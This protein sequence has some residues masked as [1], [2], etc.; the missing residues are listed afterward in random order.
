MNVVRMRSRLPLF[1]A[2]VVMA[3]WIAPPQPLQAATPSFDCAK[4]GTRVE[5]AICASDELARLDVELAN[6]YREALHA[7]TTSSAAQLAWL[8]QRNTCSGDELAQCL[9]GAMKTRIAGLQASQTVAIN[10]DA[11]YAA[12]RTVREHIEKAPLPAS[13]YYFIR[14][15]KNPDIL[16]DDSNGAMAKEGVVAQLRQQFSATP[17]L[18]SKVDEMVGQGWWTRRAGDSVLYAVEGT[19]GTDHCSSFVFFEAKTGAPAQFV[20]GS[21]LSNS[22]LCSEIPYLGIIKGVPSFLVEFHNDTYSRVSVSSRINDNWTATC[23]LTLGFTTRFKVAES[24]CKGMDCEQLAPLALDLAAQ[25]DR[26][27]K[28]T[29]VAP[30]TAPGI[31]ISPEFQAMKA[32]AERV[33]KYDV[34]L[35]TF[36]ARAR[37]SYTG[38][39]YDTVL[40]PVVFDGTLYL[41][42]MSHA[43]FGYREQPDFLLALYTTDGQTLEPV[44]GMYVEKELTGLEKITT[45]ILP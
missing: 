40:F 25:R 16:L 9:R 23:R 14:P 10:N 37:T 4:A 8:K 18:M 7:N 39:G 17:E 6:A 42:R 11:D 29:P 5:Q 3:T 1:T 28:V 33:N 24:Y 31:A 30:R 35:P 21:K 15:A 26:A 34:G 12:C 20:S 36:G 45:E 43:T 19:G 38:F 2:V 41:A 13:G 27:P 32:L 44:A 22:D